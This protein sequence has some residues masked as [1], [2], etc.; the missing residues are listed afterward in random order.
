MNLYIEIEN[1][2][3][4]NHPALENNLI[5]VFGL[6]PE[7]WHP[8]TRVERPGLLPYQIFNSE[9]STYQKVND[10]WTDV[11]NI[12]DMTNEEKLAK[13]QRIKDSWILAPNDMHESWIF[14]EETCRYEPL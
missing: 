4:K 10:T 1:G 9:E 12:R 7:H 3:P 2:Q 6:I 14:N 13:Q 5:Q 8:F 11:W